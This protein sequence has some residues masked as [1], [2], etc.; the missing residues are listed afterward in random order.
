MIAAA[1]TPPRRA[2]RFTAK[3]LFIDIIVTLMLRP[4]EIRFLA[5]AY[6]LGQNFRNTLV[7]KPR[8]DSQ[9][10]NPSS[11]AK[12][13]TPC[14]SAANGCWTANNWGSLFDFGGWFSNFALIPDRL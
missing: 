3:Q 5:E 8:P 14:R 4:Q 9:Q 1:V 12:F 10:A 11:C 6:R 2:V 7:N 13:E